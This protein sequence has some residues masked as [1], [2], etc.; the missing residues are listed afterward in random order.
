MKHLM[1]LITWEKCFILSFSILPLLIFLS[2]YGLYTNKF[3]FLK[4]DNYIFSLLMI[5]HVWFLNALRQ[6]EK[7]PHAHMNITRNLEYIMY[8]IFLVYL[9]KIAETSYILLSYFEYS[10]LVL[11]STFLP[12]G[13]FILMLQ[14]I[15]LIV[16]FTTF[17]HRV[18]Q[19]GPYRFDRVHK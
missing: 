10:D 16:T 18:E 8:A 7:K 19:I 11:P 6:L 3:Y 13:L 14:F 12:V 17:K 9:F 1:R 5:I 2:F 15:L 4:V